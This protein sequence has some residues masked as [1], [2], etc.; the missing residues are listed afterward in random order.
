MT[1]GPLGLDILDTLRRQSRLTCSEIADDIGKQR[2]L[3]WD[4][5][6]RRLRRAGL[7]TR[8]ETREGLVWV[9]TDAGREAWERRVS[10]GRVPGVSERAVGVECVED[11]A[12]AI[13]DN[14]AAVQEQSCP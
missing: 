7:V 6:A 8:E 3:V 11:V 1:V 5:L 10:R 4:S 14:T 13:E 12:T 9:L 2:L